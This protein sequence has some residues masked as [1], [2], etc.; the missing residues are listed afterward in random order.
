MCSRT[1]G[2][3]LPRHVDP[4]ASRQP[5]PNLHP[6]ALASP[7]P[8][9]PVGA[10]VQ[11]NHKTRMTTTKTKARVKTKTMA[12]TKTTFACAETINSL[13]TPTN[14]LG[15]PQ[16]EVF[17]ALL[18]M[19][20]PRSCVFMVSCPSQS[21]LMTMSSSESCNAT[22]NPTTLDA[23]NGPR[24]LLK[25]EVKFMMGA[26]FGSGVLPCPMTCP[27]SLTMM[28]PSPSKTSPRPQKGKFPLAP[29]WPLP[30]F[31]P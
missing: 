5:S 12:K 27:R 6:L 24:T 18:V 2:S 25:M 17:T 19:P 1:A 26:A 4:G 28:C 31:L 21:G 16:V 22:A 9:T 29:A 14:V 10:V 30:T 7:D 11:V 20:V 8:P 3:A 23:A 13:S 15:W